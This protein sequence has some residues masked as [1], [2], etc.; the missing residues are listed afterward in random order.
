MDLNPEE[1]HASASFLALALEIRYLIYEELLVAKPRYGSLSFSPSSRHTYHPIYHDRWGKDTKL[2]LQPQIL[3][4]SKQINAEATPI[5]YQKNPVHIEIS[6]V[7]RYSEDRGTH[8]DGDG[9]AQTLLRGQRPPLSFTRP[10]LIDPYCL[11]RFASISISVS[12]D[13]IWARQP[14]GD[15]LSPTCTL[16]LEL[17]QCLADDE[18]VGA[19]SKKKTLLFTVIKDWQCVIDFNKAHGMLLF[20]RKGRGGGVFRNSSAGSKGKI[21][22]MEQLAPILQALSVKREVRIAEDKL[23]NS[24]HPSSQLLSFPYIRQ[25]RWVSIDDMEGL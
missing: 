14:G 5:L 6:T 23:I 13:S 7:F 22:L 24:T 19:P 10:G 17:L 11:Q 2:S 18:A 20:P 3:R 25:Q 4:V 12:I 15:Y 9:T 1:G 21:L 8:R 16:L